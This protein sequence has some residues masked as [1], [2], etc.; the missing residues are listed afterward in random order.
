[1]VSTSKQRSSAQLS[2]AQLIGEKLK[3]ALKCNFEGK[4]LIKVDKIIKEG[5]KL[6]LI[7]IIAEDWMV[8]LKKIL[9]EMFKKRWGGWAG[10]NALSCRKDGHLKSAEC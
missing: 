6:L 3:I 7:K 2:S 4:I 10:R 8:S 1:M 5:E 9:Q